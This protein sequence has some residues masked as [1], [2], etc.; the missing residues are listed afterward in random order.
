[1]GSS[2]E[3]GSVMY[4]DDV[5]VTMLWGTRLFVAHDLLNT[6]HQNSG[7]TSVD[8]KTSLLSHLQYPVLFKVVYRGFNAQ[9]ARK[10][11]T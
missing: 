5:I 7:L 9:H 8:R 2:G 4:L 6:N 10:A 11:Q 3:V 1:M